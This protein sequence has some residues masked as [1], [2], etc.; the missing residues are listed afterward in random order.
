MLENQ[1]G[2]TSLP[3][4]GVELELQLVDA[5]T[6]ALRQG[7]DAIFAELPAELSRSVRR[8]FH[9]CCVEVATDVCASV[10]DIRRDLKAKLRWVAGAAAHRGLLLAWG[11]SHPFSH[12]KDQEVTSDPRYRAL[13]DT[14]QETL[15]R[16]LTFGL[17]VH[18]GVKSG[19]AAIRTCDRMREHLPV[20]LALSANSP[21][22]CGR[23]TGLQ[24]HRIEVMG[25]LP[26]GGIPPCFGD[27]DSFRKL[28]DELTACELIESPKDLWWD[29]RP[30]PPHGTVEVR[31]CDMPL[32]LEA[33]LGLTALIECLVHFLSREEDHEIDSDVSPDITGADPA[34]LLILQ[35]NRWLAA[36]YGLDAM[37]IDRF[38]R[39]KVPA[40]VLAR[41]LTDRLIP[42]G[43]ELGCAE[44]LQ[45]L[46]AR[47][48]RSNDAVTQVATYARTNNLED[49]ARLM[50]RA[51][52]SGHRQPSLSPLL[53]QKS[54]VGLLEASS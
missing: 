26:I 50:T 2:G 49:V 14:F 44:Y 51:D 1:F 31:I 12:W 18:V 21:F 46:R 13:A 43:R 10:D 41:E 52:S 27:W 16:Q 19:D 38:T 33:V 34:R 3:T 15:R 53:N 23:A 6:L 36:R 7:V 22:W 20:L 28:V 30:S 9:T 54:L 8:E 4:V 39:R 29:V 48:H 42:V 37:L 40:R 17:H 11:G 47:T 45:D 35:Q 24:S 5:S 25:S 32:G